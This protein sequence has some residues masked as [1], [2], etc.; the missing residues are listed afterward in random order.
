MAGTDKTKGTF[1]AS[2]ALVAVGT[3]AVTLTTVHL[4]I[5]AAL[6]R[7]SSYQIPRVLTVRRWSI[8]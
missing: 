8:F 7:L 2:V 3:F 4:A 1:S 5:G 6:P